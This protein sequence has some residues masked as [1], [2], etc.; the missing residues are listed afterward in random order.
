MRA[1]A[2]GIGEGRGGHEQC[3]ASGGRAQMASRGPPVG[4]CPAAGGERAPRAARGIT[5][6]IG[7]AGEMSA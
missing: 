1:R 2:V 7:R 4:W 6:R 3:E 5:L